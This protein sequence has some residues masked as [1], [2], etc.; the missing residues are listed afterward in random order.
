MSKNKN[1]RNPIEPAAL[2][3]MKM[4]TAGEVLGYN[5]KPV[6]AD[7][8]QDSGETT[9]KMAAEGEIA[10]EELGNATISN[11]YNSSK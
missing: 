11:D 6:G 9:R 5:E 10:A 8:R 7:V 3:K 4:E 1:R 2:D